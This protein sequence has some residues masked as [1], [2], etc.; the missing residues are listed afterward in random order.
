MILQNTNDKLDT[1]FKA[2]QFQLESNAIIFDLLST[3]IYTDPISAAIREL[4]CNA[5]DANIELCDTMEYKVHLPTETDLSFSVRD[6]GPG[7]S[8][9]AI[10]TLYL[11]M[12]ASSKRESNN[13]TGALGIGKLS[14]LAYTSNFTVQSYF[15]GTLYSYLV[16]KDA[17]IPSLLD[18]GSTPTDE[19]N[20]LL[21]SF[22]VNSSDV[23]TF[24][25]KATHLFTWY[26][27]KPTLNME[28]NIT[29]PESIQT[30]TEWFFAEDYVP[31]CYRNYVLMSNILYEIPSSSSID[32]HDLRQL[33]IVCPTG[34]VSIN[35]GRESLVLDESTIKYLNERLDTI[36][37]EY[38]EIIDS[39]I[40]N[41][42]TD[43][44][45]L[46]ILETMYSKAPRSIAKLLRTH[47][48][49]ATMDTEVKLLPEEITGLPDF[50]RPKYKY[51]FH[52]TPRSYDSYCLKASRFRNVYL[53]DVSYRFMDYFDN[54]SEALIVAR[55]KGYSLK[56]FVPL[57][58]EWLTKFGVSYTKISE[59]VE[60]P[61]AIP[62]STS[63]RTGI[64]ASLFN[65]PVVSKHDHLLNT[66][67]SYWYIPVSGSTHYMSYTE[68]DAIDSA[69][70]L[71]KHARHSIPTIICVA[72]KYLSDVESMPNC[73][74][75]DH[76]LLQAE[77]DKASF[78]IKPSSRLYNNYYSV[79]TVN[80]YK[81]ITTLNLFLNT[82]CNI[83]SISLYDLRRVSKHYNI[84]LY[85]TYE[86]FNTD[87]V[88]AKYPLLA[89]IQ[90]AALAEEID[91]YLELVNHVN[92]TPIPTR[93][94]ISDYTI[95]G[96][97]NPYDL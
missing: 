65:G 67:E 9:E 23:A 19:P 50:I 46:Q 91:H 73:T 3:K 59:I 69:T 44:E 17:G 12:G 89:K 55:P 37:S 38:I 78:N 86:P 6:Y 75:F 16:T 10:H 88:A 5:I 42:T 83:T 24:I 77:L 26:T 64:Y 21:V 57:A 58:E 62:T 97:D 22:P 20:G 68:L 27:H 28:L 48:F 71:L 18:L 43:L 49:T 66:S 14:P 82:Y 40:Q 30:S 7:L 96:P 13:F 72:K 56:D 53:V 29:L 81:D 41:A 34:S 60:K 32:D 11:T 84:K 85:A 93:R 87:D 76:K 35:P 95:Y 52:K 63:T 47:K 39:S 25:R 33:V 51:P 31:N 4:T 8:P 36:K 90:R 61:E 54:G 79:D 15:N 94:D 74:L 2:S 80:S 1:S 45:R 70:S 92:P